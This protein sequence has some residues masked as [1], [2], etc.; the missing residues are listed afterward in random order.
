LPVDIKQICGDTTLGNHIKLQFT[1]LRNCGFKKHILL[2]G[3]SFDAPFNAPLKTY[4]QIHTWLD[5]TFKHQK[6]KK[7]GDAGLKSKAMIMQ[8]DSIYPKN[9]HAGNFEYLYIRD[10]KK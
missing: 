1:D 3:Y 8:I 10:A 4:N 2:K 5:Q 9:I 6:S 7:K